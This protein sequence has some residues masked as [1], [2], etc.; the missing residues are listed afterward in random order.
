MASSI[1]K[2]SSKTQIKNELTIALNA[3]FE[4]LNPVVNSMMASIYI[5]DVALRPLVALDPQGKAYPVLIEDIPTFKNHNLK[6]LP[7]SGLQAE[8]S[9]LPGAN[10]GDGFPVTC[11][12]L[13][14]SWMVGNHP[15]V[16]A[17]ARN[18]YENIEDIIVDSK[19]SK[20]CRIIFKQ[21]QWNFYLNL[22]RPMAAHLEQKIFDKYKNESQAYERNSLYVRQPELAGLYNGPYTVSE[23]RLGSHVSLL[24][25]KFFYGRA[26]Y[27]KK[28]TFKFIV[29]SSAMEAN[30]LT[31]TVDV[32]SSA[33]FSFDQA[34]AFEKKV[35]SK[36][37]PFRVDF[38]ASSIFANIVFNLDNTILKEKKVRI[39][40]AH[41]LNRQELSE[42]FF[43]GRQKPAFHFST[44]LDSW[45][46]ENPKDIVIYTFS[47]AKANELLQ[48]AGWIMKPDGF[49]YK[50]GKKLVL[51]M[52]SVVDLKLTE[53]IEVYIQSA[54]K[55]VGVDLQIK[56][57]PARVLFSQVLHERKFELGFYSSVSSPDNS[58]R[59]TLHSSMIPSA[60]NSWSG[61]NRAG[62]KN[63]KVDQWLDQVDQEF[64]SQKRI[65]LMGKILH[66]YTEDLPALTTYYRANNSVV[67]LGLK[68]YQ[69][70]S[71]VFTEYLKIEDWSF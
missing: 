32:A 15:N 6:L 66:A 1:E 65:R 2:S 38:V 35:K 31:G 4:T 58:Q 55:K 68:N 61:Y 17:P 9:F 3:E 21:A 33:G 52:S 46:T 44:P 18:N 14:F 69:L 16:S 20:K 40:L 50:E 64:D 56:N 39:A 47:R 53:M 30:L 42:A 62:W 67:P 25:N 19:E 23:L 57:Y 70:T 45:Y 59:S 10:W 54:W 13:K 7:N 71:G 22:P 24:P 26:P 48:Q 43:E 36:E 28:I 49:R 8:I 29:N 27:F 63:K 60:S 41:A 34:I 37:L 12:D 51:T 11:E 5:Q